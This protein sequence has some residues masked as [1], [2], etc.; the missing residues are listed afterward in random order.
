VVSH[1]I[2]GIGESATVLMEVKLA[3]NDFILE[4]I[5]LKLLKEDFNLSIFP[6]L[7][8]SIREDLK[9]TGELCNKACVRHCSLILVMEVF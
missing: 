7:L 4:D 9:N 3:S 8:S 1:Y 6:F 2:G 5:A